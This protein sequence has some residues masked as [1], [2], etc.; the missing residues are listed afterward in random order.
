MNSQSD[1]MFV[2]LV[3]RLRCVISDIE[4]FVPW[5]LSIAQQTTMLLTFT[6]GISLFYFFIFLLYAKH[7]NI[8][9]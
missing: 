4:G 5:K 6:V 8:V 3:H 1:F 2:I 7:M 9:L